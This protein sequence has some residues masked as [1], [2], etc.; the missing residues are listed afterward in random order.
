M[1]KI[2]VIA[3]ILFCAML[4]KGAF[5][6]TQTISEAIVDG[7]I[8][9]TIGSKGQFSDYNETHGEEFIYGEDGY[10]A[11]FDSWSKLVDGKFAWMEP[12]DTYEKEKTYGVWVCVEA[13]DGYMFDD[14]AIY[15]IN[16]Q[17]IEYGKVADY[18]GENT[19][20]C[21]YYKFTPKPKKKVV[22]D[23]WPEYVLAEDGKTGT[24][25][26]DEQSLYIEHGTL[27]LSLDGVTWGEPGGSGKLTV[28]IGTTV[29][30]KYAARDIK[31]YE[32]S[33]VH[34]IKVEVTNN[35]EESGMGGVDKTAEP[36]I[37]NPNTDDGLVG[38]WILCIV[39]GIGIVICTWYIVKSILNWL[40]LRHRA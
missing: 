4:T 25:T 29:Y 24:F 15:K 5:A 35:E 1:K 21:G 32:D 33:E 30:M 11:R 20:M 40:Y 22:V 31:F 8:E 16:G 23:K 10:Y 37:K 39:S 36:E 3:S 2:T 17:V 13:R 9:A 27:F 14:N 7:F 38:M 18:N 12:E 28:P 26:F 6:T 19:L 34:S